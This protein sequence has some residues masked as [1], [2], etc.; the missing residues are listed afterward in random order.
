MLEMTTFFANELA[1]KENSV[2]LPRLGTNCHPLLQPL[3]LV[4]LALLEFLADIVFGSI[5]SR[6]LSTAHWF[7]SG[8][9]TDY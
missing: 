5:T 3:G 2:A 9:N 8:C 7:H 1:H 4:L 6:I